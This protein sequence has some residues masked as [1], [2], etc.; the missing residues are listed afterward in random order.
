VG[1]GFPLE[2]SAPAGTIYYTLDGSDPRVPATPGTPTIVLDQGASARALIPTDDTLGD[3]WKLV[4]FDDS[5][6]LA[7][8]TGIGYESLPA[9]YVPLIGI[10]VTAARNNNASVYVRIPFTIADQAELD[11]IGALTLRMKYD[12][13]FVASINGVEVARA[14]A[15]G[16]V[17]WNG[18]A[19]SGNPDSA[20]LVFQDF[21]ASA[22]VSGLVLGTNV[23]AIHALNSTVG[24]SDMLM[25]PQLVSNSSSA[26]GISPGALAYSGPITLDNPVL[27]SARVLEGGEWS[28]LNRAAFLVD[29]EP[30]DSNNLAV[31][32]IHYHPANDDRGEEFIE[33]MNIGSRSIDLAGLRFSDGIEF[34]FDKDLELPVGALTPGQ[35][36]V[37]VGRREDFQNVHPGEP[38][39]GVFSGNLE[40]DGERIAIADSDGNVI[41]QFTYNDKFPWPESADGDGFSLVLIRPETNPDHDNPMNWRSSVSLDGNPGAS[42]SV[43]LSGDPGEDEDGDGRSALLEL[44]LGTSDTDPTDGSEPIEVQSISESGALLSL[45]RGIAAD[46]VLVALELSSDLQ[47][48]VPAGDE[49]ILS[50]TNNGDGTVA[51][52]YSLTPTGPRFFM[53]VRATE[54]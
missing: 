7:G 46:D 42:D 31:T 52:E 40:N 20:A 43:L 50:R 3:A 34:D 1:P 51:W 53:R 4:D 30:A 26:S 47:T 27:A 24:S 6:W 23:L 12:D 18:T 45:T 17:A 35:R 22:G 33:L 19:S 39:A 5:S 25:V 21:D 14:N 44:A 28:A 13:G 9:D 11:E 2:I 48:W 49:L 36:I 37:L 8:S 38:I 16:A 29:T 54:R 10:D 41:R 15:A 32:E